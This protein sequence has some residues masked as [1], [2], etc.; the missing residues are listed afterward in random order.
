MRAGEVHGLVGANGAGKSTLVKAISGAVR[1]DEGEI[2]LGDFVGSHLTPRD[3]H[4]QGL[5]TIYQDSSLVPTFGLAQNIMLGREAPRHGPFL[6]KGRE[7]KEVSSS[8]STVG[9]HDRPYLVA[10]DLPPAEQQLL[11]VAAALHRNA[12]IVLMDEPTAAMGNTERDRLFSVISALKA[13]G[14]AILYISHKL[15][16]VL[17]ICDRVTVIRDGVDVA[18]S[19]SRSLNED[20]L[21][22]LMIGRQL[23]KVSRQ[24][25]HLGEIALDVQGLGQ[26]S[27]LS[28]ISFQVRA[29][30]ILGITGLVGSG[31]SRL[32]RTIFGAESFDRGAMK[33]FGKAYKPA[34][35]HDAIANGVGLV[36]QDRR[37]ESLLMTMTIKD[38][39]TMSALPKLIRVFVDVP[40]QR[41]AARRWV[42]YLKIKAAALTSRPQE[43]SGGNQQKV[44]IARWLHADAKLVIFDEPGQAVD[45]GAK[46]EIFAAIRELA[47]RGCAV[48][49]ISD[50]VEELQQMVD[51]LLVMQ[52][53][54]IA[55]ELANDDITEERVLELSMKSKHRDPGKD[56]K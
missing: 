39:I 13:E 43:L 42:D 22:R 38:N 36:P 45:A 10:A 35:P 48:V 17:S 40:R 46:G 6:L 11:E 25:R 33:L 50:E 49:V 9:L 55:G 20:E 53:G 32:G 37:R 1:L 29:G 30:E 41:T 2:A 31:R 51:R 5:A 14:V 19:D 56:G 54:H 12:R 34:G 15:H 8:L 26:G 7:R 28:D 18:T 47:E 16:E 23:K 27:R 21:V 3:A 44:A 24:T 52:A 4:S